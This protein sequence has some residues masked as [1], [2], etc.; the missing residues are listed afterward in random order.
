MAWTWNSPQR[1][2]LDS[3]PPDGGAAWED[4]RT[5][6]VRALLEDVGLQDWATISWE[7][8]FQWPT[9]PVT[10]PFPS[11][12][13]T[14]LWTVR[15][16]KTL[17]PVCCFLPGILSQQWTSIYHNLQM[18]KLRKR[19]SVKSEVSLNRV[20]VTYLIIMPTTSFLYLSV[21]PLIML[22]GQSQ[23][24]DKRDYQKHANLRYYHSWGILGDTGIKCVAVPRWDPGAQGRH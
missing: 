24:L 8:C 19:Y 15:Q 1:G 16:S 2:I 20:W 3:W 6:K 11:W 9:A 13:V 12:W 14:F 23:I 21:L 10:M 7:C 17:S 18:E 4:C 5:L 22:W